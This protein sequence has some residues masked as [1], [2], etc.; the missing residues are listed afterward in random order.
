[1]QI[2]IASPEFNRSDRS[3][4]YRKIENILSSKLSMGKNV[5]EFEKKFS[6]YIGT[7]FAVAMN[8]CTS[9]LEC[10]LSFYSKRGKE[11]ILPSQTFI[12]NGSAVINS[13]LKPVFSEISSKHFCL[14][15]NDV[16]KKI[17]KKT[18]AVI[19]VHMSGYLSYDIFKLKEIC[20]KKKIVLIEDC[21]H[22][23]GSQIKDKKAGTF[24]D[25]GCFSFYPTKI[26]TTG[27]GGMLTTNNKK[28]AEFARSY[29]NR[30]RDIK[31]NYE[32][33]NFLGRNVRMTEISAVLGIIQLKKI[34][35]FLKNR[36]QVANTYKKLLKSNKF[37]N[38]IL[39]KDIK[40]TSCWK[41]PIVINKKFNRDLIIKKLLSKGIET[42]KA[43]YPPLHL[44]PA[45]KNLYNFKK[46]LIPKTEDLLSRHICLP[47]HQSMSVQ[48]AKYVC[49]LINKLIK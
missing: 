20:K 16:K 21:A 38:I 48:E 41:I 22:A 40:Q 7:K 33:Y 32:V 27:E 19:I 37:L 42:D 8:S 18:A 44:Q 11:V 34:K 28:L 14:D 45:V 26:L 4:L 15:I 47:S 43:Y 2:K 39:P 13:G 24:G 10:V 25:A 36:R 9:T 17:S 35:I 3:F 49:K 29:Q 12:A 1:M 46:G 31:K 30:G 23:V 6:K 5:E